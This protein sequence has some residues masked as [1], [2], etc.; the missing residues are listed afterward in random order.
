MSKLSCCE[1]MHAKPGEN[2]N[3]FFCTRYPPTLHVL[4][5]QGL[6]GPQPGFITNFPAVNA[7]LSCG[8]FAPKR[9]LGIVQ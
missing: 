1:C 7:E 8:E 3:Q 5:V 9:R 6:G 2:L 4:M